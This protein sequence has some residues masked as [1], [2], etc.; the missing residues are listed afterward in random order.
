MSNL[1]D[2]PVN[3]RYKG[4]LR[5]LR[6]EDN[7]FIAE[8]EIEFIARMKQA[9]DVLWIDLERAEE[10][11]PAFREAR[12]AG[13]DIREALE[14]IASGGSMKEAIKAAGFPYWKDFDVRAMGR[15]PCIQR[16]YLAAKEE[17]VQGRLMDA[18]D[19]LHERAVEGVDEPIVNHLGKIVGYKKKYSDS[20]LA[21]QLKAL[22]PDKYTDRRQ[23]GMQG[24]VVNVEMGLRS[25]DEEKTAQG[26]V[27]GLPEQFTGLHNRMV[28][29]KGVPIPEDDPQ[30]SS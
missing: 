17:R 26:V 28:D 12:T 11:I 7:T 13:K 30:Q 5:L 9:D 15:A 19:A 1:I 16:L 20:L 10:L 22:D 2:A 18:E 24:L 3:F 27:E 6:Q 21:L 14:G 4:S 23:E 8:T 25:P 29:E